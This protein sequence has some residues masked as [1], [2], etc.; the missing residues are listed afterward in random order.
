MPFTRKS[1]GPLLALSAAILVGPHAAFAQTT[2]EVNAA[3]QFNFSTPGARS[4]GLGGAFLGLADD[5]TAAY[6]NPA[7]LTA[8]SKPEVSFEFR[9]QDFTT[10]FADR[11]HAFAAATGDGVDTIN[12]IELGEV[13][14]ST[15]GPSFLSFVYPLKNFSVS[16]YRHELANFDT[17]FQTSGFFFDTASGAEFRRFPIM[18]DLD[19]EI[20]NTGVAAGVRLSDSFSV[21][22][23]ISR[24]EFELN[25]LTQRFDLIPFFTSPANFAASN[26]INF[27]EQNGSDDDVTFNFGFLWEIVENKVSLGGVYREGPGFQFNTRNVFGPASSNPGFVS[28]EQLADFNVPDV[29]G[30]GLAIRPTQSFTI[31]IDVNQVDYSS[32]TENM[33]DIFDDSPDADT[34]ATLAKL[35]ADD[36]TEIHLGFEYVLANMKYPLA[37]RA[38]AWQDEDHKISF[39]GTPDGTVDERGKSVAFF[40]GEDVDHVALGLGMVFGE[41]FQLDL[42]ADLSDLVDTVILSG[43]LRFK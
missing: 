16:V 12:G 32:L 7:G 25:S 35:R 2:A 4:L 15:S 11:G 18:A 24:H 1:V 33:V 17:A 28:A 5:A 21:G 43:V 36:V 29:L 6:A 10:T 41:T 42:G 30:I 23:G 3:M 34:L 31:L 22:L 9:Q 38:G 14:G 27:Q 19:L 39:R 26:Q 37:I 40:Q 13:S 8:L 20:I